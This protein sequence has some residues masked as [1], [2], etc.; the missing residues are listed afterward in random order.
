MRH[1][2]GKQDPKVQAL[3]CK[4]TAK[5]VLAGMITNVDVNAF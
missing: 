2:E 5:M 1:I 4:G 3:L